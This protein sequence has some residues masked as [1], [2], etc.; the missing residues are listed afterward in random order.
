MFLL[1]PLDALKLSGNERIIS[2]AHPPTFSVFFFSPPLIFSTSS[3]PKFIAS[4][5]SIEERTVGSFIPFFHLSCYIPQSFILHFEH[6]GGSFLGVHDWDIWS[7][8]GWEDYDSKVH[9]LSL[10]STFWKLHRWAKRGE[11]LTHNK[12]SVSNLK[13]KN[14]STQ[15]KFH[16]S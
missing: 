3:S 6:L 11:L 5:P 12:S 7:R 15:I 16:T 4:V 9:I 1:Y 2:K 8:E 14:I 10:Y 13:G